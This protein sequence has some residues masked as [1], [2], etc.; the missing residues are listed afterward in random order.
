MQGAEP[1]PLRQSQTLVKLPAPQ[2]LGTK[3]QK[4]VR[5]IAII[6]INKSSRNRFEKFSCRLV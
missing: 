1:H 5:L 2:S 4:L 3:S 6:F